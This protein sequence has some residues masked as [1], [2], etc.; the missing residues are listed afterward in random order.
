MPDLFSTPALYS[1]DMTPEEWAQQLQQ[2]QN[3][4]LATSQYRQGQISPSAFE[5][6]LR[7]NGCLNPWALEELWARGVQCPGLL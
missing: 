1:S 2:M 7:E 6:A 4:A 3:R 5:D